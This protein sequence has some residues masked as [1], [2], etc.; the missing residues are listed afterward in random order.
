MNLNVPYHLF[1]RSDHHQQNF[2]SFSQPTMR[3]QTEPTLGRT[4]RPLSEFP[5]ELL[6]M[7][8]EYLCQPCETYL[9]TNLHKSRQYTCLYPFSLVCKSL[10]NACIVVGLFNRIHPRPSHPWFYHI[11]SHS[12]YL[13]SVMVDIGEAQL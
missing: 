6:S 4:A 3:G 12:T 1:R 8:A 7:I 2:R 5:T 10:R 11:L 13:S 9:A